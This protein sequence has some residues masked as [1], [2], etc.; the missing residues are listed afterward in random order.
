MNP[1]AITNFNKSAELVNRED[2]LYAI[3][4]SSRDIACVVA[5]GF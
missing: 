3:A 1:V 5:E 4:Q 2:V